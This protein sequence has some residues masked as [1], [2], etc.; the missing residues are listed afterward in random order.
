MY[1]R[2]Q[3]A[4]Q[5]KKQANNALDYGHGRKDKMKKMRIYDSDQLRALETQGRS[6]DCA[7][8][9]CSAAGV[10]TAHVS[11]A[12]IQL[13]IKGSRLKLLWASV[14]PWKREI[15]ISI[16]AAGIFIAA[17]PQQN[18]E[19]SHAGLATHNNLKPQ[20]NKNKRPTRIGFMRLLGRRTKNAQP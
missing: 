20:R 12:E 3:L 7:P 16:H 11:A 17:P 10:G 19:V 6:A 1:R 13:P 9:T 2:H 14:C 4:A 15:R 5:S 18:A 8:R